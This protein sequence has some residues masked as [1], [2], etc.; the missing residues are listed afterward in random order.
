MI[1]EF[2]NCSSKNAKGFNRTLFGGRKFRVPHTFSHQS[3][4]QIPEELKQAL[5]NTMRVCFALGQKDAEYYAPVLGD[6]DLLNVK[7]DVTDENARDRVHPERYKLNEID[8]QWIAELK[9]LPIRTAYTRI[10]NRTQKIRS[11]RH[12]PYRT[13]YSVVDKLITDYTKHLMT[14]ISVVKRDVDG[15]VQT[16]TDTG[17]KL[18]PPPSYLL[19]EKIQ[20]LRTTQEF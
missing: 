18:L 13:P 7:H 20:R 2:Q 15:I 11:L 19:A 17:Q 5:E 4:S 14:H 12:L 16:V 8:R 3:L 9:T 10:E 6:Y 1:D